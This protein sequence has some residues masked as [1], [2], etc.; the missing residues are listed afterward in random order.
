MC[1]Y[2]E[3]CA[4]RALLLWGGFL[5]TGLASLLCIPWGPGPPPLAPG[6]AEAGGGCPQAAQPWCAHS[7][8]LA[9]PQF[10]AGY[11]CVSVGYS[12]GVTLIQTIF[13]K[14]LGPRPQ[15]TPACSI[16]RLE[17]QDVVYIGVSFRRAC[18]WAC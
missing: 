2:G 9:L 7:R 5:L 8:G 10:L 4:G 12:L 11:A 15:V 13:S 6:A 14:V 3:V 16:V 18:G 17:D 1:V